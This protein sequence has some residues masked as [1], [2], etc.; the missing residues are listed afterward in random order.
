MGKSI[1]KDAKVV[2]M[3]FHPKDY[4]DKNEMLKTDFD[5]RESKFE[6]TLRTLQSELKKKETLEEVLEMHK[7]ARDEALEKVKE[8]KE[9]SKE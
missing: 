8:M 2:E 5:K 6:E 4:D 7:F 1:K 9:E 3:K